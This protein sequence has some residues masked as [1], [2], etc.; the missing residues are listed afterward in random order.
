MGGIAEGAEYMSI[1]DKTFA[2]FM[3]LAISLFFLMM[4][5]LIYFKDRQ[6]N[7]EHEVQMTCPKE[8]T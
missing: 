1:E 6:L 3:F 8:R 5:A 4:S 2:V 7:R